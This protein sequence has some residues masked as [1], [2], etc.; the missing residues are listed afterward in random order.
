M[1]EEIDLME[2]LSY[3]LEKSKIIIITVLVCLLCGLV[4]TGF[5]KDAMYKSD[6][7]V[8]LVSKNSSMSQND[9]MVNQKLASTYRE[10]VESRSV[11][12]KVIKNL[13]LDYSIKEL[14]EMIVVESVND[15]EILKIVVSSKDPKE[16]VKIANETASAF[17]KEIIKI[18]NLENVSIVDKAMLAKEPYNVNIIKDIIIYIGVGLVLSVGVLFVIYYFDNSVKSVEQIE[19]QLGVAVIGTVPTVGKKG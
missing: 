16:A 15:T 11:L 8:V 12:S 14:Q 13:D 19:R 7:S 3:F 4:Y 6:V 1:M 10:L 5:I 17:E 18:Y 9:I 2:L